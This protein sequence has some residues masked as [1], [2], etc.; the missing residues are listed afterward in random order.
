MGWTHQQI[1]RKLGGFIRGGPAIRVRTVIRR[2]ESE[3]WCAKAIEDIRARPRT[4]NPKDESQKEV[5]PE[6]RTEGVKLEGESGVGI[7]EAE[8]LEEP[9]KV[10]RDFKITRQ[11][12][13]N[14]ATP[15]GARLA[16]QHFLARR[17]APTVRRA[18]KDLK[19]R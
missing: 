15:M 6:S 19:R 13:G 12:L 2:P 8:V 5:E 9:E 11:L 7:K 16:K 18:E 10:N 1:W 4:P 14:S 3:R 17:R